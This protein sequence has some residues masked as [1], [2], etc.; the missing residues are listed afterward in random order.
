[1]R[2][3]APAVVGGS[4]H[5]AV[6]V[7]GLLAPACVR[8]ATPVVVMVVVVAGDMDRALRPVGPGGQPLR[9]VAR[10]AVA[11]AQVRCST[12][13]IGLRGPALLHTAIAVHV[14]RDNISMT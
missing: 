5:G 8:G 4:G 12:S 2:G 14:H 10:L 13:H 3:V 1:M 7:G 9:R 6:Q 11:V